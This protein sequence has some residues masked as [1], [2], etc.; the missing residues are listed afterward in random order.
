MTNKDF[1]RRALSKLNFAG[2][3]R[4]PAPPQAPD[5]AAA[6]EK[7][8]VKARRLSCSGEERNTGAAPKARSLL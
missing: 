6:E 3:D 7:N 4:L 1:L 8:R 2:E 5:G